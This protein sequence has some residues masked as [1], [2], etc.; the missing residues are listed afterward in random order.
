MPDESWWAKVRETLPM[1]EADLDK[2]ERLA[3]HGLSMAKLDS[4]EGQSILPRLIDDVR[5]LRTI[6]REMVARCDDDPSGAE[7][8]CVFCGSIG[9]A[10]GCPWP[11][12]LLSLP[13]T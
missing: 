8:F 3:A 2:L 10:A 4:T 6:G 12:L 9:H 1:S 5:R 13:P 11:L 7:G